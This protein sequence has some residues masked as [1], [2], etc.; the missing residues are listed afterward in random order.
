MRQRLRTLRPRPM[1]RRP[2]DDDSLP[3]SPRARRIGGWLAAG[4]LIG[5]IALAFRLLGGNGDGTVVDPTPSGSSGPAAAAITFGTAL[6]QGTGEVAAD[7]RID[8]FA[9]GDTFAY[10][11]PPSGTVPAVVYVEV[12]RTGGGAAETVQAPV[13]G[14]PV[15]NPDVIAFTVPAADLLAAFGAGQY[16]MLIYADPAGQPI[17]EGSFDLIA[18]P[19]S[20]AASSSASP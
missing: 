14:Q 6:D 15:R 17:A 12:R 19:V 20:P 13:E 8:R 18:S 10:S 16:L 4:L 7:S 5:G 1:A 2:G 9:D 3:L 11:V